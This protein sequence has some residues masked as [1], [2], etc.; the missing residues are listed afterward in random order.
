[1]VLIFPPLRFAPQ[2]LTIFSMT[3]R[4]NRGPQSSL[5]QLSGQ[6]LLTLFLFPTP[7]FLNISLPLQDM[8]LKMIARTR[9]QSFPLEGL[10][11][12][13]HVLRQ[14]FLMFFHRRETFLLVLYL[15][16][17]SQNN[18]RLPKKTSTDAIRASNLLPFDLPPCS[19]IT[20]RLSPFSSFNPTQSSSRI[21][22]KPSSDSSSVL[23]I[24]SF[25]KNRRHHRDQYCL[26][27][28][29]KKHVHHHRKHQKHHH[30]SRNSSSPSLLS[31]SD[32]EAPWKPKSQKDKSK[33]SSSPAAIRLANAV[34]TYSQN[35]REYIKG[36]AA[37]GLKPSDFPA[38]LLPD[39]FAGK[40]IDIKNI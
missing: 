21:H 12:P 18:R 32:S 13:T 14:Q 11:R 6:I 17:S 33:H 23:S 30:N 8:P 36:F 15:K 5:W 35:K 20:E 10:F 19:G 4:L 28:S 7:V 24:Q 40:F 31:S 1:M 25:N 26:I 27:Q 34:K 3:I 37:S 9:G 38:S 16:M 22:E 39:R 29:K 2:M